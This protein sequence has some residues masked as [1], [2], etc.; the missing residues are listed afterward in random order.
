M[1]F[2]VRDFIVKQIIQRQKIMVLGYVRI[3]GELCGILL[4][5]VIFGFLMMKRVLVRQ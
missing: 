1:M 5:K 4:I 2:Q 3:V